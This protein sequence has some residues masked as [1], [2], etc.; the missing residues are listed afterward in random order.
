VGTY[1]ERLLRAGVIGE[2]ERNAVEFELP[3]FREF[4]LERLG[5]K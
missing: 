2:P 5:A 4:L 3:G 1:K